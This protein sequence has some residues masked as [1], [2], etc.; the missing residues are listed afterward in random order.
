MNENDRADVFAA[1]AEL[2]RRYPHWRVG[3]LVANVAGW[4]DVEAWDVED[5]QL[6]SAAR[7]HLKTEINGKE[8][9]PNQSLR[10][11]AGA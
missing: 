8:S 5:D 9:S 1:L 10:Q 11:T 6:L 4:A 2:A 3:Q 7:E